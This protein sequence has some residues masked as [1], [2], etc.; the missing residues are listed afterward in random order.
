MSTSDA[1][2]D[3]GDSLAIT[4][5]VLPGWLTLTDNGDGTAAWKAH[6]ATP[7][8]ATTRL[9]WVTDAAGAFATQAFTITVVDVNNDPVAVDDAFTVTVSDGEGEATRSFLTTWAGGSST[10]RLW[11]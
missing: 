2:V 3:A 1:D 9:S 10:Y 8:W 6:R 11:P 7:T 4:A 5:P